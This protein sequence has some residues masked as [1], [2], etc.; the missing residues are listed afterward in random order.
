VLLR[1]AYLGVT[2]ALAML[3]LLPTSDRAKDA[4]ILAL[5]HQVMVL[6]LQLRGEKVRFTPA[7]RALLAALLHRLPRDVLR[8]VR[9]L[10]RPETV[11]R[12]RRDLLA[13]RHAQVSGPKRV[14]RPPTVR[15][16][17]VLVLRLARENNGWGY[18]RIHGELLVLGIKVAA[19]TVWEILKEA[20]IDPAPERT[21]DIWAVFLRA[22]V[23]D[24]Q[25]CGCRKSRP[26][27]SGG[28]L[29][30]MDDAAEVVTSVNA[31]VGDRCRIGDRFGRRVQRSG[32]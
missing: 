22:Q 25:D 7:D 27:R 19:S 8:R 26:R 23:M 18:R 3:R 5:R 30:L 14:G 20:G 2:N 16:V 32:V 12:W 9:L 21:S 17:R 10:V 24:L 28:M 1:L 31:E 11:L 29:V 15:S 6:E 4:E 13:R